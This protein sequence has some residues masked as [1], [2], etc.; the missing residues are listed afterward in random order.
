VLKQVLTGL[1]LGF[2]AYAIWRY[3]NPDSVTTADGEGQGVF[4]GVVGDVMSAGF[5]TVGYQGGDMQLS[6]KGL[7]HIKGWEGFKSSVYLDSA[8]KPTIGYGH[9]F[10]PYES[11]TTITEAQA[12]Q[13]LAQDVSAAENGV[14][15]LVKVKLTQSQFDAL[16]SFVFNVGVGAFSR[17]TMLKRLNAGNYQSAQQAFT[18]WVYVTKGGQKVV[19]N[20]L[21]NRRLADARLFAGIA[22]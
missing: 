5:Q 19:E 11:F 14:N 3:F 7:A 4:D 10:K 13:M 8:G 22:A 12:S 1:G 18:D 17:S 15:R 2:G 20:G 9:L 16:V 6:F 21:V